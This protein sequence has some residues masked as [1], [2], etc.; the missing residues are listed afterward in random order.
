MGGRLNH[1]YKAHPKV[2]GSYIANEIDKILNYDK[3]PKC[4]YSER[5]E[6]HCQTIAADFEEHQKCMN[7]DINGLAFVNAINFV[8]HHWYEP[9]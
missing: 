7:K 3:K 1:Q 8:A 2:G 6:F 9:K 4:D 5:L